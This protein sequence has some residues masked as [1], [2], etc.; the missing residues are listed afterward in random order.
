MKISEKTQK[1]RFLP[2]SPTGQ[3]ETQNMYSP[4]C[5]LT[6]PSSG[7]M[8]NFL[9]I[10]SFRGGM[11]YLDSIYIKQVMHLCQ[12]DAM[13]AESDNDVEPALPLLAHV[14]T[15]CQDPHNTQGD[16]DHADDEFNSSF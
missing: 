6:V 8:A 12:G 7:Q 16:F 5:L 15:L 10:G 14:C 2:H 1:M 13:D 4:I 11:L 9:S 3:A